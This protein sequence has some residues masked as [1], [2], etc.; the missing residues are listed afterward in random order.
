MMMMD[1]VSGEPRTN[2]S[3]STFSTRQ[4]HIM[5]KEAPDACN[6][7]IRT[8]SPNSSTSTHR[9]QSKRYVELPKI[10]KDGNELWMPAYPLRLQSSDDDEV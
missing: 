4:S 3:M 7:Y 2:L 8:T 6:F 5:A 9:R 10:I 1:I